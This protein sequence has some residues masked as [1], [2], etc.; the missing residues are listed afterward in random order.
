MVIGSARLLLAFVMHLAGVIQGEAGVVLE[1][2]GPAVAT[3]AM[4]NVA[5][6]REF[7][8][9]HAYAEPSPRAIEIAWAAYEMGGD[10]NGD[11]FALSDA[12][13][14][15]LGVTW[16]TRYGNDEWGITVTRRW[17]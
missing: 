13:C 6:G 5:I 8:P 1:L 11:L 14:E 9:W 7:G 3:V 10:R 12:D 2:A 17:P 15:M 4:N 16:G